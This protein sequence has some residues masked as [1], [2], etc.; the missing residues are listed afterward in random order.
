MDWGFSSSS[1][2]GV[3]GVAGIKPPPSPTSLG[4]GI[5]KPPLAWS[6]NVVLSKKNPPLVS[7]YSSGTLWFWNGGMGLLIMVGKGSPHVDKIGAMASCS[8]LGSVSA[9]CWVS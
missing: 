2:S 7:V 6:G 5:I 1:G 8:A 3:A 4:S 9:S